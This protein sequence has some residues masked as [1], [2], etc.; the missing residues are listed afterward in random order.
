MEII[1]LAGGAILVVACAIYARRLAPHHEL[2]VTVAGVCAVVLYAYYAR[3]QAIETA[4]AVGAAN[5][6]IGVA[7]QQLSKMTEQ[8]QI[9]QRQLNE[10]AKQTPE[11][12]KAAN[13]AKDAADT[14][15]KQY[16]EMAKQTPALIQ[17]A[18]AKSA[19][20][21]T[22]RALVD[23]ERP[24]LFATLGSVSVVPPTGNA[25]LTFQPTAVIHVQ[26]IGRQ[27]AMI[28]HEVV[29]MLFSLPGQP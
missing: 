19:A 26:N 29:N 16:A 2:T 12:I 1:I 8:T 6:A 20:E 11:V 22:S 25:L 13:A 3:Q 23:V 15:A 9:M 17:E 21:T 24:Y 4:S 5:S 14:A 7:Q 28:S 18:A 27:P 10:I